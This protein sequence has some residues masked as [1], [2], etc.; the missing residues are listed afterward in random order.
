MSARPVNPEAYEAYLKGRFHWH[1]LT[2]QDVDTAMKF[3]QIAMEKDPDY[4]LAYT[5]IAVVWAV[6]GH[7]GFVP[8]REGW[9]KAKA[10]ALKAIEL[11]DTLGEAHAVLASHRFYAEW[12]WSAAERELQRST[13]WVTPS[14]AATRRRRAFASLANV[15]RSRRLWRSVAGS[16]SGLQRIGAG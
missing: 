5:G 4:A 3:F 15:R 9:G 7:S 10:A 6:R 12:D 8:P 11:D 14:V 2:P 1:K 16:V 13:F